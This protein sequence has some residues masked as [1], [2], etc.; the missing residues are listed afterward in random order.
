M[1]GGSSSAS[2]SGSRVLDEALQGG[3]YPG[4]YFNLRPPGPRLKDMV[5][6]V[7]ELPRGER[8]ASAAVQ[9]FTP[10]PM[11]LAHGH[12]ILGLHR[13]GQAGALAG[14]GAYEKAIGNAHILQATSAAVPRR[15]PPMRAASTAL[16]RSEA[17]RLGGECPA[18]DS[19][20]G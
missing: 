4:P 12:V 15:R 3:Q 7:V 6:L 17:L 20:D 19:F 2:G 8:A 16:A 9:D 1:Q 13:T 11:T 14:R 5:E 10:T 18:H